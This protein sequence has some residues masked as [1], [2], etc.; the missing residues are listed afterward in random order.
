MYILL[1][2]FFDR[3]FAFLLLFA[4]LPLFI[5]L[6]VLVR[7]KLGDPVVFV[8]LRSGLG[9]KPFRLYKFRT[10]IDS[11]DTNGTQVPD[12]LRL[13]PFGS[14]LRSTSLDELPELFNILIG[15]MSFIGPRP[16]L[17][18]Y[19]PRYSLNQFRRHEVKPGLSGLAQVNGRNSI[20]WNLKFHY[21][22]W[23]VDHQSACLDLR[24]LLMTFLRVLR[25]DG[26]NASDHATVPPFGSAISD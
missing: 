11:T 16:L 17:V 24:I 23:Y 6:A 14:F 19:L 4:L 9:G 15:D 5:L 25:R 12:N 20:S 13:T 1:K 21:D 2:I 8:Q 3:F 7:I 18:E 26:I 22:V 10:M